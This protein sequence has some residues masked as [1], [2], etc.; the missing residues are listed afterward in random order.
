MLRRTKDEQEVHE[1]LN[2]PDNVEYV[3]VG[4]QD[5]IDLTNDIKNDKNIV[6]MDDFGLFFFHCIDDG[7]YECH[8]CFLKEGRG[9]HAF[10]SAKEAIEYMFL[11][12]TCIEI[13][14]CSP[15]PY[16]HA[17]LLASHSG[18]RHVD[19]LEKHF[20]K[21]GEKHDVDVFSINYKEWKEKCQQEQSQ[22]EQH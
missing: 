21:K 5:R 18:L 2:H 3:T 1:I 10:K 22:V 15:K 14:A 9:K 12:T 6:L 13:Y 8:P 17:R 20:E 7:I 11:N 16:K 4:N 19:T